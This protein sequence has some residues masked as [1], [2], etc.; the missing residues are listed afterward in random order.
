M[1]SVGLRKHIQ[2][3]LTRHSASK[4]VGRDASKDKQRKE[5]LDQVM[6]LKPNVEFLRFSD[7][8]LETNTHFRKRLRGK[9]VQVNAP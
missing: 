4:S 9:N 8:R 6:T 3:I 1:L 7:G 2:G 5:N